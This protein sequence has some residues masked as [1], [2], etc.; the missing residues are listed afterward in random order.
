MALSIVL[1][2]TGAITS[3]SGFG[4]HCVCQLSLIATSVCQKSDGR[5][6]TDHRQSVSDRNRVKLASPP[7]YQK[8]GNYT[9]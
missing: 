5:I 7:L 3:G 1:G 8:Q 9:Y 4:S 6:G 2:I